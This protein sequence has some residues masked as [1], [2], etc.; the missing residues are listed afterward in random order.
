[1]VLAIVVKET[2]LEV[3]Q[4]FVKGHL[5]CFEDLHQIWLRPGCCV[6]FHKQD[7]KSHFSGVGREFFRA[8]GGRRSRGYLRGSGVLV[9]LAAGLSTFLIQNCLFHICSCDKSSSSLNGSAWAHPSCNMQH[10]WFLNFSPVPWSLACPL[11]RDLGGL[12]FHG[13]A[14]PQSGWPVV[15]QNTQKMYNKQQTFKANTVNI[16]QFLVAQH[17]WVEKIRDVPGEFLVFTGMSSTRL[18]SV[19]TSYIEPLPDLHVGHLPIN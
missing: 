7:G 10:P 3:V 5:L 6:V 17:S 4:E 1:M 13:Q 14:G 12:H 15:K 16:K 2:R 18:W 8:R 11:Q 19:T 9:L